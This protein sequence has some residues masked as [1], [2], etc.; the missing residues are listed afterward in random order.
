VTEP[1][2]LVDVLPGHAQR[3]TRLL[4]EK[5]HADLARAVAGL[6]IYGP[7]PCSAP[8]CVA[9]DTVPESV[10]HRAE[11]VV[12]EGGGRDVILHVEDDAIVSIEFPSDE[13][14]RMLLELA[15]RGA[16]DRC[17]FVAKGDR[18]QVVDD[19]QA[20]GIIHW[21]APLTTGF[22]CT[23]PRGTVLVVERDAERMPARSHASR[24]GTEKRRRR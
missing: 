2:L 16:S 22:E 10:E 11:T 18:L 3:L 14:G 23:L 12:V 21:R 4:G 1:P 5:G 6:R 24:S 8:T 17:P 19:M 15:V 7:C 9:F 13:D 20:N